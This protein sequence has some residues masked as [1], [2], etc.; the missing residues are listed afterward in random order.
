MKT[1]AT[2]LLLIWN[3][4]MISLILLPFTKLT[5]IEWLTLSVIIGAFYTKY[6]VDNQNLQNKIF[7]LKELIEKQNKQL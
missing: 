6:F 7:E 2:I 4:G 1:I 3:I 5:F